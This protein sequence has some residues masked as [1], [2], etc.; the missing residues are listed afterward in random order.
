MTGKSFIEFMNIAP[1]DSFRPYQNGM[2]VDHEGNLWITDGYIISVIGNT[3]VEHAG[4]TA[5]FHFLSKDF[6]N[7]IANLI[8]GTDLVEYN[9]ETCILTVLS[10]ELIKDYLKH[11]FDSDGKNSEQMERYIVSNEDKCLTIN[12]LNQT[13]KSPTFETTLKFKGYE[14]GT[15]PPFSRC[16]ELLA[17]SE[18]LRPFNP[19]FGAKCLKI[20][21]CEF[22]TKN[23]VNDYCAVNMANFVGLV[24]FTRT[25]NAVTCYLS[26][27]RLG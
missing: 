5:K 13:I 17:P 16:V 25:D 2:T 7:Y 24:K 12:F 21:D 11:F 10:K 18:T 3:N 19:V 23:H 6:L 15:L 8:K 27:V 26:E 4:N 9:T 20:L 1:A 22:T 14:N